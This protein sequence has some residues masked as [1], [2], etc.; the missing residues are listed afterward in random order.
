ME[1]RATSRWHP[2]AHTGA[3]GPSSVT[4]LTPRGPCNWAA[5]LWMK[6]APLWRLMPRFPRVCLPPGSVSGQ[7]HRAQVT[8]PGPLPRTRAGQ[9]GV[10]VLHLCCALLDR[11]T[12]AAGSQVSRDKGLHRRR[13]TRMHTPPH[14]P[15]VSPADPRSST[16][17]SRSEAVTDSPQGTQTEKQASV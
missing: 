1:R 14:L 9:D 8:R 4:P 16:A 11:R 17:S 3:H 13:G 6:K 7:G 12:A 2:V 10:S 5:S 15:H